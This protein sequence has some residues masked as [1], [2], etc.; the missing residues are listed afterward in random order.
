MADIW[1]ELKQLKY[2]LQICKDESFSKAA[3]NLYITQQGLSKAIK[4]L[5]EEIHAPVFYRTVTG[6]KLTQ[7]GEYL[8][9]KSQHILQETDIILDDLKQMNSFNDGKLNVAFSFGVISALTPAFIAGFKETYPHI[10]LNIREYEDYYCEEAVFNEEADVGFTIAPVEKTKFNSIVVKRDKM[11]ILVNEHNPLSK[12]SQVDFSEIK[13][14]KFIIVNEKFKLYHNFIN[15][16]RKAGFEPEIHL[17]TVE[18]ILVHNLSRLNKGV[19]VSVYFITNDVANVRPI[20][21]IDPSCT[22]EVCLITKKNRLKSYITKTF[23]NY[24]LRIHDLE[25]K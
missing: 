5:E 22:W 23:I 10:E 7:Y 8:Q 20:T 12:K 3:K 18:L 16:C 2:F 9:E 4:H 13:N 21:F 14:E 24:T 6:I 11:C 17:T 25:V 19:G 15:K 1:V